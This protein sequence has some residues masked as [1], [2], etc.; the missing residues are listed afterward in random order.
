MVGQTH[1]D[2]NGG[3]RLPS[4]VRRRFGWRAGDHLVIEER[5]DGMLLRRANDADD[6]A[7]GEAGHELAGEVI[8]PEDFSS[9]E[10]SGG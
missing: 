2:D 7:L 8:E 6:V 10:N 1:L 9:W 5:T 3:V 4:E